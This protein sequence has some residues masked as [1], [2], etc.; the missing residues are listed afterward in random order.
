MKQFTYWWFFI[1]IAF[2]LSAF[3]HSKDLI[4]E[5]NKVEISYEPD[6]L[7]I[8]YHISIDDLL[9][10]EQVRGVSRVVDNDGNLVELTGDFPKTPIYYQPKDK[11]K[12][13]LTNFVPDY[14]DS[15]Y[16]SKTHGPFIEKKCKEEV[17]QQDT[18][19]SVEPYILDNLYL[20]KTYDVFTHDGC[21]EDII[22]DR[23]KMYNENVNTLMSKRIEQRD[24]S[25]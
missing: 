5:G 19:S 16:L 25:A 9:E 2:I 14:Q 1:V 7:D 12:Y 8:E 22:Y 10:Q 18:E 23:T 24:S 21:K 11:F 6:D 4:R 17:E 3:L 15:I 13:D 20:S